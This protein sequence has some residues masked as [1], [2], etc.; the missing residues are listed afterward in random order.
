MPSVSQLTDRLEE[1]MTELEALRY[2]R[3]KKLITARA[4]ASQKAKIMRSIEVAEDRLYEQKR[5]EAL[6]KAEEAK[7]K[8]KADAEKAK[9]KA[10]ADARLFV[11]LAKIKAEY[12]ADLTL[13][14]QTKDVIR[15]ELQTNEEGN[16][17]SG[18][19]LSDTEILNFI[20]RQ[21][22]RWLVQVGKVF[23]TLNDATRMRLQELVTDQLINTVAGVGSDGEIITEI[24]QQQFM[25]LTRIPDEPAPGQYAFIDE[26]DFFPYY[27]KTHLNLSRYQI[28]NGKD[29]FNYDDNCLIYAF[30]M[31]NIKQATL[32]LLKTKVKNRKVPTNVMEE[33][34]DIIECKI[35]VKTK[36]VNHRDRRIYGKKYE[37]VIHI[38][39]LEGHY[40]LIEKTGVTS[41]C[42]DHYDELKKMIDEK[43]KDDLY[44]YTEINHIYNAQN[45]KD[46]QRCIDSY[47][48]V[49]HLLKNKD[50][51]LTLI[52]MDDALIATTQ[53]YDKINQTIGSLEY[54]EDKCVRPVE[55][56]QKGKK[57]KKKF[58][59]VFFDF[60]TDPNDEHI[61]YL[62]RTYDGTYHREFRGSDCAY[63]MLCS[64]TANTRF[65]AHN[66]T[67]DYRFIISLLHNIKEISRGTRLISCKAKFGDK[68][69][70]IKDSYHL[71]SKPL[72]EFPEMFG[73]KDTMKEVMP[74]KL[75]TQ[76]NIKKQ[77]VPIS[78]ALTY[79]KTDDDKK[80]FLNNIE[81]WNLKKGDDYDIIEYSSLYCKIDCEI[82]YK[83]YTTF[84]EWV[85]K[86][87][88]IDIDDVLTTASLADLY[89]KKEGCYE[90]VYELSGIPQLFIQGCVVGGR[91]MCAE[92]KMITIEGKINDFDAVSL[93]PSAMY[94]M[95]G[96]LKGSPNVLKE[97][98][99]EFLQ[100]KTDGYFVDI[101]IK[102][103]G[104]HRKFPL[105][106]YMTENGVRNF[107]ND[108]IGLTMRVDKY[109]LEDL[110]EFQKI[111]FDIVRGYY[112]D[113]GFNTKIKET[114]LFC[115][116]ERL[117]KKKEGNP[118]QEIYKLLMNSGYGKTI[119]K[120]VDSEV[121]FFENKEEYEVYHRRHYNWITSHVYFGNK[122]R[123][124]MVKP[125]NEHYN[126]AH[127]G[128][129]ILSMSKRI[130]NE[131]MSL[132]EDEKLDIFYQD[133]DSM[134]IKDQDI[135]VL[136]SK[137]K[138]VYGRDLIGKNFGQFH[139][140]FD[141]KSAKNVYSRRA[142]FLGKKAYI[143][144]LVGEDVDGNEV[145]DYHIRLKGIPNAVILD[146][147]KR[148]GR[149]RSDVEN[150]D[151]ASA[152]NVFELYED[153]S[154][155]VTI[156]F[157]LTCDGDK[158][159]FK[160]NKDYSINTLSIFT[161]NVK[162]V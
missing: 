157:D 144:E 8:R 38:G 130:M 147:A 67:Y 97:L 142:I 161:R 20:I 138:E 47:D 59:N 133:T 33:I 70:Q 80:Q 127:I 17:V 140:D 41:Y 135:S 88:K 150:Y 124:D 94:R 92:N 136:S 112:F 42:L 43:H 14:F 107:T 100:E 159:N 109:T 53:F 56:K 32:D 76:E 60:E 117:K 134:H 3:R 103:V 27:H 143:D 11:I 61:P 34:A 128:T 7:A 79:I 6:K 19:P 83:G 137:F 13:K 30:K 160:F 74:Y 15:I 62:C 102:S 57:D 122:V 151:E 131:V 65:I 145:I 55:I 23:Y 126:R 139:S 68:F 91:T 84:R 18:N 36:D 25:I 90:D 106:S 21:P 155:G 45:K 1:L 154:N 48:L 153:L 71:I 4:F 85:L 118:A 113:E 81:R 2:Y 54:D 10:E 52:S 31:A 111:E 152:K 26:G 98:T 22:G 39:L 110:I 50:A 49:K 115:F 72:R 114:I 149:V 63:Q 141:I 66:A 120:P 156:P 16:V 87:L 58:E 86:D 69:V 75:Y 158:A 95:D 29:D 77:F 5:K 119:M 105:M 78:E 93:Y 104:I 123:C 96:F 146:H 73:I 101:V 64:M 82:L 108:M 35:V 28:F 116:E 12:I 46:V 162:Y 99:Y 40:F 121:K 89:F 44:N 125:L 132:A 129:C 24:I 37:N 148:F 51:L 9:K